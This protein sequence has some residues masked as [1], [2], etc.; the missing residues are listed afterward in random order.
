MISVSN[1]LLSK[2]RSISR[3]RGFDI[4]NLKAD[5]DTSRFLPHHLQK[6]L[7]Y[8]EINC[9]FDVGANHGQFASLLRS[10]GYTG[11]IVSVEPIPQ[12]CE[13]L[14]DKA[15]SDPD[16]VILNVALGEAE[17][18]KPFNVSRSDD[19]SSLLAPVPQVANAQVEQVILVQMKTLAGIFD[20]SVRGIPDPRV[21]LKI[22][23]QGYDVEVVKGAIPV[24]SR[25]HLLQTEISM[26]PMYAGMPEYTDA[27]TFFRTLDFYPSGFFTV[28]HDPDRRMT[29]E[30][31]VV[32]ARLDYVPSSHV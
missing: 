18:V 23:A 4:V 14:R 32:L 2:V 11:R 9:V 31:D 26:T 12:L 15:K 17:C 21:F 6:H 5:E 27:L 22:D 13:V 29:I 20:E 25:I 8:G 24:L 19:Y 1:K 28:W 3:R 10:A 30:Y 7:N 16:W